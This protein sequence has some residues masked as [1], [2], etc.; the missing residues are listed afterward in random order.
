MLLPILVAI[1]T[2]VLAPIWAID[3]PPAIRPRRALAVFA[4]VILSAATGIIPISIAALIGVGLMLVLRCLTHDD[5]CDNLCLPPTSPRFGAAPDPEPTVVEVGGY[6][7][8]IE[9]LDSRDLAAAGKNEGLER[10]WAF[11]IAVDQVDRRAADPLPSRTA[12]RGGALHLAD[13]RW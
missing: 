7:V 8:R 10:R 9:R 11:F 5:P 3:L 12:W 6:E 1:V 4:F 13:H 2:D